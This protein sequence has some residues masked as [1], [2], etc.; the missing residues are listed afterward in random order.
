MGEA[1]IRCTLTGGSSSVS[2]L[3]EQEIA[4]KVLIFVAVA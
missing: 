2:K 1:R 4:I 3:K